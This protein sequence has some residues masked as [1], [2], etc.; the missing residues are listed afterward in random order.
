[1]HEKLESSLIVKLMIKHSKKFK[2]KCS[3]LFLMT[4]FYGNIFKKYQTNSLKN[5]FKLS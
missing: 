3:Y 2:G 5:K 1:M 4:N